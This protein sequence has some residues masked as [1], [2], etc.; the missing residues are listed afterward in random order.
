MYTIIIKTKI[1]K[2]PSSKRITAMNTNNQ[3][4]PI[5]INEELDQVHRKDQDKIEKNLKGTF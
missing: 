2:L 1:N 5:N 3:E 4:M